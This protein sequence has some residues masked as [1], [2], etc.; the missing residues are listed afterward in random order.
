MSSNSTDFAEVAH[1]GGIV[2]FHVQIEPE[3]G[4]SFHVSYRSSRPVPTRLIEVYALPPGIVIEAI[5][6]AGLGDAV[7][8][9]S[10]PGSLPVLIG[11]D[12]EGHFGHECPRCQR[13]WR[14][15]PWPNL[16]PYC[17]TVAPSHRYLSAAQRRYVS[18]YVQQLEGALGEVGETTTDVQVRIDLDAIADA[19]AGHGPKP[20]FYVAEERQQHQ[21]RCVACDA[22]ND[23]IGRFGYCSLCGTRNDVGEFKLD[24]DLMRSR[25]TGGAPPEQ[26]VRDAV[27]AY[28]ALVGRFAEQLAERVPMTRARRARLAT[29]RFHD[30]EAICASLEACC[31][32]N[33]AS[34]MSSG[35]V[36]FLVMMFHR[37]HVYEHRGGVVD[38][39]YLRESGDASV[40][41]GQSIR[42]SP[43]HCHRLLNLLSRSAHN[44]EKGFHELFPPLDG[45]ISSWSARKPNRSGAGGHS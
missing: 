40:R 9:P 15:E 19:T 18:H 34:G 29:G 3:G 14:G 16:C 24:L 1:C 11:S 38:Q 12:S 35:E 23:I 41:L 2:T 44:I 32:I 28:D 13:Y 17:A 27:S 21:F 31:D 6:V 25:L 36:S 4:T 42:E 8:N 7:P 30:F 20:S 37:R 10:V 5:P 22:F 26:C 45:P 33:A 39:R 43:E